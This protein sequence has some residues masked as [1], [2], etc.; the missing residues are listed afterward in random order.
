MR[1]SKR[2]VCFSD[3]NRSRCGAV[4]LHKFNGLSV[5]QVP[6]EFSKHFVNPTLTEQIQDIDLV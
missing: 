1:D 2:G 4:H 6:L 5:I 3:D